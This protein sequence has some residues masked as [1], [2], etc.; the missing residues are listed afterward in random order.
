[1]KFSDLEGLWGDEIEGTGVDMH[2][3]KH[4]N[5]VLIKFTR[6][7]KSKACVKFNKF[8]LEG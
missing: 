5:S 2:E 6:A 3:W 7:R 1:M 4:G 8:S